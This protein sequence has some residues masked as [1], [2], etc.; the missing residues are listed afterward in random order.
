MTRKLLAV[1]LLVGSA[2]GTTYYVDNVAGNDANNGTAKATPWKHVKGMNG[3]ASVCNSTVLAGG[4]TVVFKGG[5]TWTMAGGDPFWTVVGGSASMI[6]YTTDHGWFNGGSFTQPIIDNGGNNTYPLNMI[7]STGHFITLNDFKFTG[8]GVTFVPNND[9]QCLKF[10]NSHDITLTG[11]SFNTASRSGVYFLFDPSGAGSF[12]N[13]TISGNDFTNETGG[14]WFA[15]FCGAAP[16]NIT[17]HNLIMH[18][19]TAH[20]FSSM[21][22]GGAHG[23]GFLHFFVIPNTDATQYLDGFQFYDNKS[24]GNFTRGIIDPT[25]GEDMTGMIYVEGPAEG[26][27]FNNEFC[28]FPYANTQAPT[29]AIFEGVI[30]FRAYGN[31]KANSMKVYNNTICGNVTKDS[32]SAGLFADAYTS[33]MT[34]R[35]NIVVQ[36]TYCGATFNGIP[37][38]SSSNFNEYSCP[39]NGFLSWLT[40]G[41]GTIYGTGGSGAP[42]SNPLWVNVDAADTHLTASSPGRN[43]GTNLTAECSTYTALCTDFDGVARPSG[44]TPWDMGA[45]QYTNATPPASA[46]TYSPVAGTYVSTQSVTISS[47]SAGAIKCYTVNGMNPQTNGTSGCLVGTL[48]S[49]P[50]SIAATTTLKAVAGGTGFSDS[51]VTSGLYIITGSVTAAAPTFSPVQGTYASAQSVTLAST[52][53]GAIICYN[54]SGNPSTDGASG[55]Q[56]GSTLYSTAITVGI[57]E[58]LFAVAGGSGF[59]DSPVSS[60]AYVITPAGCGPPTYPCSSTSAS[61]IQTPVAPIRTPSSTGTICTPGTANGS[62]NGCKG[63]TGFDTSLNPLGH[64]PILRVT[65]GTVIGGHSPSSTPSGGDSDE[66]FNCAGRT[67]TS[68]ACANATLYYAYVTHGGAPYLFSFTRNPMALFNPVCSSLTTLGSSGQFSHTVPNVMYLLDAAGDPIIYKYTLSSS[69][70]GSCVSAVQSVV[71][72]VNASC[73]ALSTLNATWGGSMK[74]SQDDTIFHF[75]LSNTGGQDTGV[76]SVGVKTGAG[77]GCSVYNVSTGQILAGSTWGTTGAI[78]PSTCTGAT[79]HDSSMT[80]VSGWGHE[81][82][83]NGTNCGAAGGHTVFWQLGTKGPIQP[84]AF[85][86]FIFHID[87]V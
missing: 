39:N 71:Y 57:S 43:I 13:F 79:T 75:Q 16:C 82:L 9:M 49:A 6:T 48:Y 64:N 22:G 38:S 76:Y 17:M 31:T 28:Y 55:C 36:Q 37:T 86:F 68:A 50:V 15:S 77:G 73:P 26:A 12:S 34:F 84:I 20:D 78:S 85:S 29:A 54:T 33:G 5:V 63:S 19:N 60:A 70:A 45:F 23:D 35:N 61:A 14:V 10:E 80:N 83:V 58:T 47:S 56:P 53:G 21:I 1:L 81:S 65:D 40:E 18:H 8:C 74:I 30:D 24:Y 42:N 46:P 7:Y 3:C 41:A 69:G 44:T 66:I 52:S 87:L 62:G 4:D 51:A 59:S 32:A 25:H 2:F 67:D 27:I 72:D 11:N